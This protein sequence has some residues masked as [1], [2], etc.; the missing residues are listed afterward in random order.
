[1]RDYIPANGRLAGERPSLQ[2]QESWAAALDHFL[3]Q[4]DDTAKAKTKGKKLRKAPRVKTLDYIRAL[5][6]ALHAGLGCRLHEFGEDRSF[7][8]KPVQL[9]SMQA[10]GTASTPQATSILKTS[11]IYC[12]EESPQVAMRFVVLRPVR[13]L[14]IKISE[15]LMQAGY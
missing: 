6:N 5:D 11:T 7:L 8:E 3:S 9:A 4:G 14:R 15:G 10:A 12:D 1:M 13:L 2:N